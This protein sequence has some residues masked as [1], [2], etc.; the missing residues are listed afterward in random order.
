MQLFDSDVLL[1]FLCQHHATK[2]PD[3]D[4]ERQSEASALGCVSEPGRSVPLLCGSIPTR[5][6]IRVVAP[7]LLEAKQNR[8]DQIEE[9]ARNMRGHKLHGLESYVPLEVLPPEENFCST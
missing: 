1:H 5:G 7:G 3:L 8:G 4:T 2:P 6:H 9:Q